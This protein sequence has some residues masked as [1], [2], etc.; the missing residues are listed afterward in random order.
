MEARRQSRCLIRVYR[1]SRSRP[2]AAH[3]PAGRGCFFFSRSAFHVC[4][5]GCKARPAFITPFP[6]QPWGSALAQLL[7]PCRQASG[8][9]HCLCPYWLRQSCS[10]FPSTQRPPPRPRLRL[11]SPSTRTQPLLAPPRPT[12]RARSIRQAPQFCTSSL[13]PLDTSFWLAVDI[14]LIL[15]PISH[16]FVDA[17]PPLR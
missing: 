5:A 12:F 4:Y 9:H 10:P 15:L 7:G 8:N 17:V 3:A 14:V 1:K 2:A 11:S 13:A 6:G 16:P